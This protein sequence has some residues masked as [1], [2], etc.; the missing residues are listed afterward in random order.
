MPKI[1][2]LYTFLISQTKYKTNGNGQQKTTQLIVA[3]MQKL[4]DCNEF[5]DSN[6]CI[7]KGKNNAKSLTFTKSLV[8]DR[9][10]YF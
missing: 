3:D 7:R 6:K 8:Q 9:G 4:Y 5:I 2:T 10:P 1:C